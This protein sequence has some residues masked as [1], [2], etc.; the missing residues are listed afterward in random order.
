[1]IPA[2]KLPSPLPPPPAASLRFTYGTPYSTPAGGERGV[3]YTFYSFKGGVGRS[4]A[5][6][7]VAALLAKWGYSVLVVDWDVEAPGIERFF[8]RDN[9][10]IQ[11]LR[12]NTPGI[13]DLVQ[14]KSDGKPLPWG[15]CLIEVKIG[16]NS[17][18]L[19][20]L[21][22]GR[23]GEDYTSR[24]HALSFPELFDKHDL[25]SY[26]E[27]LRD[28]WASAFQFVLVDSR[29][30]VTDIGGICT[31]HL[32]DV[33]VLLFTTTESSTEGALQILERARKGQER[34][35]RDRKR[36]FAVPVPARDESRTEY[37]RATQWK[38]RFAECFGELYRDWLPSGI[39][40][41]DAIEMLRIPYVPYWSFGEQLPA[42]EEGTA[43]PSSLGHA[44]EILA[45]VL[46]ARLDWYKALEG[47]APAPPPVAKVRELDDEW[48]EKHTSAAQ[49]VRINSGL[50][51]FMEVCAFCLDASILKTQ[52]ELLAAARQA[53]ALT[54]G[55]PIGLVLDNPEERPRPTNDGILAIIAASDHFHHPFD[56]W[57]LNRRG[58]F[59]TLKSLYEDN[60]NEDSRL[61][62]IKFDVRIQDAAEALSYCASLYKLLGVEPNAH[63]ELRVRYGGLRGRNLAGYLRDFVPP[64][65]KNLYEDEV[66]IAPIVFRL[67]S[68]EAELQELVKALCAPLFVVFDF[69]EFPDDYYRQIVAY[70]LKGRVGTW[71][72]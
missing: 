31:V 46:A 39:K 63:I 42:I 15:D 48:L 1:M 6:A 41:R 12:A 68:V 8:A 3:I 4:M 56:Y 51:G 27:E 19:S 17:S 5:L 53:Q 38:D 70:F 58:D 21:T 9:P 25:G 32:A 47:R 23:S 45:R 29:T 26:I 11:D 2:A 20:L 54:S 44:Y 69:A 37:E 36:L 18:H 22:A 62:D 13:V 60:S 40:P 24:L 59:Y 61:N 66:N 35:P 14:A 34:L 65:R 33:L 57:T 43:D 49:L 10:A 30:G 72:E 52:Q 7:N 67:G 71:R 16:A 55:R 64:S 50:D 28:E